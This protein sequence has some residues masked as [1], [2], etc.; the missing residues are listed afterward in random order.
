MQ[1]YYLKHHTMTITTTDNKLY[2]SRLALYF[3]GLLNHGSVVN[4]IITIVQCC[5]VNRFSD[6]FSLFFCFQI[7]PAIDHRRFSNKQRQESFDRQQL[8]YDD[9]HREQW[10]GQHVTV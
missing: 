6:I 9:V 5:L 3:S 7:S 8:D 10:P 2:L 4:I 1:V